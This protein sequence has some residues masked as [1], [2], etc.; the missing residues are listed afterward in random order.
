M[1]GYLHCIQFMWVH[2]ITC[3]PLRTN[4]IMRVVREHLRV[5]VKTDMIPQQQQQGVVCNVYMRLV[6]SLGGCLLKPR[7]NDHLAR[8]H[9]LGQ[10]LS[11][12]HQLLD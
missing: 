1:T 11:I 5:Y 8:Q 7:G 2:D 3:V 10:L 9:K 4:I 6:G 12:T